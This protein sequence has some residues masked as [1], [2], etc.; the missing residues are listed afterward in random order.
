MTR[1][2]WYRSE[3][4]RAMTRIISA[5]F[6]RRR[7]GGRMACMVAVTTRFHSADSGALGARCGNRQ[8]LLHMPSECR[9]ALHMAVGLCVGAGREQERMWQGSA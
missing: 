7:G 3:S 9:R 6:L 2:R 1:R 8:K 5:Y 4:E